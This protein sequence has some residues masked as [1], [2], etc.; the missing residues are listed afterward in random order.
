VSNKRD[1][2][3][4]NYLSRDFQTIKEDLLR[5]AKRYYPDSFKDFST[6][7]FGALMIDAV[8]YTSDMLSFY[9]DYQ[10]NESF[11]STAIEYENVLKH[12][13]TV[14]YKHQGARATH[15]VV[16]LYALIPANSDASGPNM[17]YAPVMKAGSTLSSTASALFTLTADVNFA[18]SENEIVVAKT[19][20]STGEPTFY[21]VRAA[22][23]VVSGENRVKDFR[24]IGDFVKFRKLTLPGNNITEIISV[25]DS[26]GN[27]YFEVEN[28][29]Q[30]TIFT[31]I[32]NNDTTTNTTAPTVIKP[33]IVPRRFAVKRDRFATNILFGYGSDSELKS[34]SMAEP[35]DIVMDLHSKTYVT[36]RAFD[37]SN[38]VKSDKF[39]IAPANTDIKVVYRANTSQNSNAAAN[40]ITTVVGADIEFPNRISL[41][42]STM[43]AVRESIEATNDS[44]IQ[45]DV[46][47]PNINDLKELISGTH[48][49]QN[50]AVTMEDYKS[51]VLTMPPRFGGV[52][53]CSIVRDIDSNL[54]NINIYVI[55][56]VNGYL[57]S[58][59]EVLKQN[60]KT[61]LNSKRV[62]N[63]S[64]DILDAKIVNLRVSF[65]VVSVSGVNTTQ[66]LDACSQ[67]LARLF[68]SKLDVGES[69]NITDIY[70]VLNSVPSV[71]DATWVK[72]NKASGTSY[73]SIN[74]NVKNMTSPDG[75][76]VRAPK[77]VI[78]EVKYPNTDI[79]GTVK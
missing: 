78:F 21:A 4:I 13:Q 71:A 46:S 58:T 9:L 17:N 2:V 69:F 76:F 63:D 53:R 60:I 54:R 67:R 29:S 6:A 42:T 23:Q 70:S 75:R 72:I 1:N 65:E 14:G 12:G 15:G 64:V 3:N 7:G 19:N 39:G 32:A 22:G 43:T 73:S 34:A 26:D 41:V 56:E 11:L 35:R 36:D 51:L 8:A 79:T 5:Y 61:W 57:Q 27:E 59:N 68:S 30:N 31:S 16:T 40:T 38:L 33:I 18:S 25:T 49:A 44:P 50:R 28:L 45:G 62:I 37:P 10:A 55:S 47:A 66:V 74:F 48:S 24:N 20:P 77:N 52:K